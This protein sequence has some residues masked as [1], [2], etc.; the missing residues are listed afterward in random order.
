MTSPKATYREEHVIAFIRRHFKP[1]ADARWR[2]FGLDAFGPQTT[3]NV[4]RAS[5]HARRVLINHPGGGTGVTQTNDTDCHKE[6]K[7]DYIHQESELMIHLTRATGRGCPSYSPQECIDIMAKIWADPSRHIEAAKGYKRTG[8]LNALNGD[9]DHLIVREAKVFWDRLDMPTKR[10]QAIHDVD[11]EFNAGRLRWNATA[12]RSLIAPYPKTGHMDVIHEF[13]DDDCLADGGGHACDSDYEQDENNEDDD[14]GDVMQTDREGDG[15]PETAPSSL[16]E[17]TSAVALT[18][19][20]AH[21]AGE[22]EAR[23]QVYDQARQLMETIGDRSS[24]MSL[25]RVIHHE[26]RKARGRLQRDPAIAQALSDKLNEECKEAARERIEYGK[27]RAAAED[28]KKA[29]RDTLDLK[30]KHAALTD[31]IKEARSQQDCTD[32][33]K[34]F[35]PEMLGQG[36]S[37]GGGAKHRERRHA[38]L[39]RL[40]ARGAELSA[41]QTNDWQWFKKEWDAQMATCHGKEWGSKFAGM[42]Q[43]LL[44]RLEGGHMSAVADFMYNET[45]RVLSL[46]PTLRL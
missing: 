28:V 30:R 39:D 29:Q 45:V 4:F 23:L 25:A 32:A 27:Q 40:L 9:E 33:V 1:A 19:E 22:F 26:T 24:A 6:L 36:L 34:S 20:Q 14:A 16:G 43:H 7:A 15:A 38:V 46:V 18:Y 41:Q 37:N 31:K 8:T 35:S 13:Q 3:D 17:G 44:E 12:L 11:V 42:V 21:V 5:W 10:E 2:L